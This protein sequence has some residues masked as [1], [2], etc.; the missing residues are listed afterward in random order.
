MPNTPIPTPAGASE[1]KLTPAM[2]TWL[3][4]AARAEPGKGILVP[5][6][7][8]NIASRACSAGYGWMITAP[9]PIFIIEDSGRAA[10][11]K[12]RSEHH[13]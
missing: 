4:E 3:A 5:K 9:L 12:A 11:A 2:K 13:D 10:L 8:R 1:M 6:A 7:A